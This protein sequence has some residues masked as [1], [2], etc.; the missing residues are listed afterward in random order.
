MK[1]VL[2]VKINWKLLVLHPQEEEEEEEGVCGFD[3]GC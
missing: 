2:I 1:K 3:L